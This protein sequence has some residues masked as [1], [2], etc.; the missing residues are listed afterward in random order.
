M[1]IE[2]IQI[3]NYKALKDVKIENIGSMAVFLGEN[4]V[5][6]STLFDVFGFM[7]TC[8][9]ENIRSALQARGGYSEVHSRDSDSD[10][11]LIFKYRPQ[12]KSPLCTYELRIGLDEYGN[13]II[14]KERL[15]YRRG[16]GGK[17]WAFVDFS[18]GKGQAITNEGTEMQNISD[19]TREE[20]ILDSPDILAIKSLGQMTRFRAAV[21]FRRFI[22]D[23]FVSDFQINSA[24]QIQDVAYNERLNRNGDNLANVAQ[25]IRDKYSERFEKI[26]TKMRD[27]IPGVNQV[28]AKTTEDGRILLRFSDGRFKD[29]FAARYVSDGTIKM[30]AYLVMLA[31]PNPYMLLCIEEPENQLYPHLLEILVEEFREYTFSGGQVFIST[32]SPDLVNALE[33]KELFF[34]QKEEAGYS[35]VE[36]VLK[37]ELAVKLFNEGDKLGYLWKQRIIGAKQ[38]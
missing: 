6:K 27:R 15:S 34:I 21:E 2:T 11:I 8:L 1:I 14:N 26:L 31:D 18:R 20:F 4:G 7:K 13:P 22:E 37:N 38:P 28:D 29:P 23:W 9:T 3:V 12:N 33:P 16:E 30:F 24:R 32:H 25:F 17:P 10:I 19:A 36:S 35:Q 5:G